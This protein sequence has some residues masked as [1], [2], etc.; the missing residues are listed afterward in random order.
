MLR[1]MAGAT[2]V[3]AIYIHSPHRP[4]SGV[5]AEMTPW[6]GGAEKKLVATALSSGV[7]PALA[8]AALRQTLSE[9]AETVSRPGAPAASRP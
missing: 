7:G 5:F 6:A 2:L 4:T 3:A 1:L 9:A 8:E